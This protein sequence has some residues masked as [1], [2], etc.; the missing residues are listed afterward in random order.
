MRLALLQIG[1]NSLGEIGTAVDTGH[2]II[3]IDSPCCCIQT[4]LRLLHRPDGERSKRTYLLSD[5]GYIHE[6]LFFI[7]NRCQKTT[8]Q[9][10]GCCEQARCIKHL[11]R[12]HC[13]K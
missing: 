8:L 11:L 5:F 7:S 9:S 2:Y 3:E 4:P 12:S 13:A 1:L 6:E 10:V